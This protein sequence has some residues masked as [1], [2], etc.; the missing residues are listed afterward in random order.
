MRTR[1]VDHEQDVDA[2]V[3]GV[4]VT[5]PLARARQAALPPLPP[6]PALPPSVTLSCARRAARR[7]ERG[8]SR[9]REEASRTRH[10]LVLRHVAAR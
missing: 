6:V 8:E 1:I 2:A 5:A 4:G 7:G 10:V 3:G 9:G